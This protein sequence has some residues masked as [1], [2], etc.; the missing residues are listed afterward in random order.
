MQIVVDLGWPGVQA[1]RAEMVGGVS[2]WVGTGG[3]RNAG[4]TCGR[5]HGAVEIYQYFAGIDSGM[6]P[7]TKKSILPRR[8]GFC[9][10][11]NLV[12]MTRMIL[13]YCAGINSGVAL[14]AFAHGICSQETCAGDYF[15]NRSI[16]LKTAA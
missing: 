3:G 16:E 10:R 15:A 5:L 9:W 8:N 11:R 14:M 2:G 13:G 6:D 1:G 12:W 4:G 7:G